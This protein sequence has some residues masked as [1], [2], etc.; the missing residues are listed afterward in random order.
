MGRSLPKLYK[1]FS[2]HTAFWMLKTKWDI[3]PLIRI[4]TDAYSIDSTL[5]ELSSKPLNSGPFFLTHPRLFSLLPA[6]GFSQYLSRIWQQNWWLWW[7][8]PTLFYV[9]DNLGNCFSS[10][11]NLLHR[12]ASL[13][14]Y[15]VC[16]LVVSVLPLTI[17]PNRLFSSPHPR[18]H[19]EKT[20]F[21]Y[22]SNFEI[23][24]SF[25]YYL[26]L[27]IDVFFILIKLWHALLFLGGYPN[28]VCSEV[29]GNFEVVPGSWVYPTTQSI[30]IRTRKSC[31]Q[32]ALRGK[33]FPTEIDA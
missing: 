19:V 14:I 3:A 2:R 33:V 17:N 12:I 27:Q 29:F 20:L 8:A 7:F 25:P 11:F 1:P 23:N 24:Y 21:A 15:L 6:S 9:Q 32:P 10:A 28:E 26:T 4:R 5:S 16:H 31:I 13:C 22:C 30:N 18:Y